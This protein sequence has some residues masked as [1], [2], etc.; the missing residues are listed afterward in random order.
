[1]LNSASSGIGGS[2]NPPSKLKKAPFFC[3]PIPSPPPE[4][5]LTL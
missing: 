4:K 2:V 5:Y 3:V 1:M